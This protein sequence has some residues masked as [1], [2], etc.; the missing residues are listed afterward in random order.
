[1]KTEK[2]VFDL[3]IIGFGAT[4]V[5]FLKQFQEQ[6]YASSKLKKIKILVCDRHS[7]FARG[8]AF[9]DDNYISKLTLHLN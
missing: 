3:A 1:M 6:V 8:I 7:N 4:G 2:Q 9:G 5:S